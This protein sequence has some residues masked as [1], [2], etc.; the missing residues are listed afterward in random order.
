MNS[1]S[2]LCGEAD[3]V[4]LFKSFKKWAAKVR[5]KPA[6][7]NPLRPTKKK[8]AIQGGGSQ[9]LVAMIRGKGA[10]KHNDFLASLEAKYSKA[11][12]SKTP[13]TKRKSQEPSEEQFAAAKSRIKPGRGK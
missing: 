1:E 2:D 7:K 13:N 5:E 11:G 8:R 9:D 4:K 12:S 10:A 3:E 6:P